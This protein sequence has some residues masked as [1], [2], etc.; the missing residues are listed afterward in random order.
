MVRTPPFRETERAIGGNMF[1]S[2]TL[3]KSLATVLE[4]R[5]LLNFTENGVQG[6]K[7]DNGRV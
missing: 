4:K 3:P 2:D 6:D 5:L 7:S 1:T